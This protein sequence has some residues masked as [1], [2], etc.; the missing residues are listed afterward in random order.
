MIRNETEYREAVKRLTAERKRFNEHKK[1]LKQE[2]LNLVQVKRALDPFRSFHLQLAEEVESYERLKLGDIGE[3]TNLHGL[4][5]A[6][7]AARIALGMTQRELA[8]RLKVDVSQV[9]RDERNDYHGAT[10]ERASRILD[11]MG[12]EALTEVR[13][14][15]IIKRAPASLELLEV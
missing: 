15:A 2:G 11:A 1:R 7:V 14:D 3:L 9:S 12:A 6:L 10:V 5:R 13:V 8:K 4:G